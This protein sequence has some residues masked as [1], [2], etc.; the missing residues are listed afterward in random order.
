MEKL[1]LPNVLEVIKFLILLFFFF[2]ITLSLKK[3]YL[4]IYIKLIPIFHLLVNEDCY[5]YGAACYAYADC[6]TGT[7]PDS[8]TDPIQC[9]GKFF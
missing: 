7:Y 1:T 2:Y 3:I 8:S 6:P 4:Y 5:I 9:T